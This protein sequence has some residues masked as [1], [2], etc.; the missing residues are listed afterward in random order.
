M[1]APTP[2]DEDTVSLAPVNVLTPDVLSCVKNLISV[3]RRSLLAHVSAASPRISAP[4]PALFESRPSNWID[5]SCSSA[6]TS[7]SIRLNTRAD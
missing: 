3:A 6:W 4:T 7:E 1:S 5:P 2:P